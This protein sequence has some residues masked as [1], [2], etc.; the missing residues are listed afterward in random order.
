[1]DKQTWTNIL[2]AAVPIV[3]ILSLVS[4][5]SAR[6]RRQILA[7]F[8]PSLAVSSAIYLLTV[9]GASSFHTAFVV[10][11]LSALAIALLLVVLQ[12]ERSKLATVSWALLG[13]VTPYAIFILLLAAACWGKTECL[14]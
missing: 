12:S 11:T 2:I 8:L 6:P 5:A 13:V 7:A 3:L 9:D 14:G 1:M 4:L 10:C